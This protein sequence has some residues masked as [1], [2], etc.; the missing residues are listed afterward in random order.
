[1]GRSCHRTYNSLITAI[2]LFMIYET[3][4]AK[5]QAIEKKHGQQK[6]L[7]T[8]LQVSLSVHIFYSNLKK[9]IKH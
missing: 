3:I 8:I 7:S 5:N 1:M 4:L 6:I 9:V 2:I